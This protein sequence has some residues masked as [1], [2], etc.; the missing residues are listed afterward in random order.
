M[1][2]FGF[3]NVNKPA[4]IT[5]RD[6]VNR[7]QRLVRPAKVGHAGTL[8]PL[9]T[10]VLVVAIGQATRLIE[11]V[12]QMRKQY[13]ATFLLGRSSDTEDIDGSV[14]ELP[15]APIPKREEIEAAAAELVGEIMQRP[16]AYSAVKIGGRRAYELAR[17]GAAVE[18]AAR[19]VTVYRLTV[20]EYA[21]PRLV[22]DVECSG[23]TYV[24]TLGRE[25]AERCGTSAVMSALAR[26]AV[27][28]FRLDE[29]VDVE[30]LTAETLTASLRPPTLALGNFPQHTVSPEE[31]TRL[32]NGLPIECKTAAQHGVTVQALD[33]GGN[34][35]AL[36]NPDGIRLRPE[37]VFCVGRREG[38]C[39]PNG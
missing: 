31:Q 15:D 33:E 28:V 4:G 6:A 16:P 35:V 25:L 20:L 9:A 5:S 3:V 29:A 24:R 34:L 12:Q 37:R 27:G 39:P 8:D 22:L 32:L 23:G 11:Y 30:T 26:T 17:A 1:D 14:L 18:L 2:L 21:Y 7:V 38:G 10:G 36:L 13:R 19:P